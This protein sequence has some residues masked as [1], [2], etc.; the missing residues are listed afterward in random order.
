[1]C[2]I[3]PE[4]KSEDAFLSA[5]RIR[6]NIS[7]IELPHSSGKLHITVSIGIASYPLHANNKESLIKASDSA[8]Y[9]SKQAG[10]NC[11]TL[12]KEIKAE[13]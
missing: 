10:K 9:S 4:T 5:E 2:I 3:L 8:M 1:M 6:K 12:A 7:A 11:S 13:N